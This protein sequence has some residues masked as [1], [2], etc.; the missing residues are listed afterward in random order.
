M[1]VNN[2]V[3]SSRMY[4]L[5]M[6]IGSIFYQD[7]QIRMYCI[8]FDSP[9]KRGLV[10]LEGRPQKRL[11]H[12]VLENKYFQVNHPSRQQMS[13]MILRHFI[14]IRWHC[15]VSS[16]VSISKEFVTSTPNLIGAKDA[17]K[18][19]TF[20]G[21]TDRKLVIHI[22]EDA[23]DKPLYACRTTHRICQKYNLWPHCHVNSDLI[24]VPA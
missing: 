10:L 7:N 11:K 8:Y 17:R 4:W 19:R 6:S 14:A 22:G 18:V 16:V 2:R 9:T 20:Q 12:I 23:K 1:M 21:I 24:W 3:A 5:K 13:S 15:C